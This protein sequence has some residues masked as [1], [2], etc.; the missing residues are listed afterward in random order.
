ML[1]RLLRAIIA[2]PPDLNF[3]T[4]TDNS[5]QNIFAKMMTAN[6][7]RPERR[8]R[9]FRSSRDW[10]LWTV[11]PCCPSGSCHRYLFGVRLTFTT[12]VRR[13][14]IRQLPYLLRAETLMAVVVFAGLTFLRGQ[15][16]LCFVGEGSVAN[17][18]SPPKIDL[19]G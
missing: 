17:C 3:S 16:R 7:Y 18:S 1:L 9:S 12:R 10:R 4:S 15:R 14:S 19:A 13:V 2:F 6:R 8:R 11:A 5:V